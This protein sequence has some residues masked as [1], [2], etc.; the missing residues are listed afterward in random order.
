MVLPDGWP[1]DRHRP[2]DRTRLRCRWRRGAL[3]RPVGAHHQGP[4]RLPLRIRAL[5]HEGGRL[6][7]IPRCF[8]CRWGGLEFDGRGRATEQSARHPEA[9]GSVRPHQDRR[10]DH[11]CANERH[12]DIQ[13][14]DDSEVAQKRHRRRGDDTYAGD[15]RH[16]RDH[17]RS[18]RAARSDLHRL[19]RFIAAVSLFH[20]TQ[21]H[22]GREFGAD[23]DHER[24]R[25]SSEGTQLDPEGDRHETDSADCDEHR[26]QRQQGTHEAAEP[27]RQPHPD[28]DQREIGKEGPGLGQLLEQTDPD[29][30]D[31]TRRHRDPRR[32][33]R[34]LEVVDHGLERGQSV[35][36]HREDDVQGVA[37]LCHHHLLHWRSGEEIESLGLCT[38]G[39]HLASARHVHHLVE[40]VH[41]ARGGVEHVRILCDEGTRE[42]GHVLDG[43]VTPRVLRGDD[44]CDL[45]VRAGRVLQLDDV[46]DRLCIGVQPI[47]RVRLKDELPFHAHS[48]HEDDHREHGQ[49]DGCFGGQA[50]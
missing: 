8:R 32:G 40:R 20:E 50:P 11:Q 12:A 10:Q 38:R 7:R 34:V 33:V 37:T 26:H 44:G 29:D 9:L 31:P 30:G 43:L 41:D 6:F 46:L 49:R 17:E 42:L 16:T 5:F 23:G 47:D 27:D 36:L 4:A 19:Q 14:N 1:S 39:R 21:K 18:T 25:H 48:T 15:C 24:S 28:E 2:G 3:R 35:A 13:G 22:Q 45:L